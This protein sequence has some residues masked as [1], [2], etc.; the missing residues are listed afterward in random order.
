MLAKDFEKVRNNSL[1]NYGLF[2]HHCLSV[3]VW[4]WDAMLNITNVNLEV[5][6]D[7]DTFIFFEKGTRGGVS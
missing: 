3:P 5:I 4:S 6:L 1:K 2:L 7:P